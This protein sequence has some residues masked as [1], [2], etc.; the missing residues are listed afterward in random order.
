[1]C[2]TFFI[3]P[4][5][6]E[7]LGAGIQSAHREDE[8][9]AFKAMPGRMYHLQKIPWLDRGEN[10]KSVSRKRFGGWEWTSAPNGIII[11]ANGSFMCLS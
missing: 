1:M 5:H 10:L 9:V 7:L 6:L 2:H 4:V 11:L 3:G 8:V